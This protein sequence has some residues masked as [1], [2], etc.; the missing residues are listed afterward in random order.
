[1]RLPLQ[2]KF[3]TSEL[4]KI[5]YFRSQFLVYYHLNYSWYIPTLLKES[6]LSLQLPPVL[7]H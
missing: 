2:D 3:N 5:R 4:A 7:T 1:M 6:H